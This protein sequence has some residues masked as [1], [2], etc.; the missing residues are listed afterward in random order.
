MTKTKL[1]LITWSLAALSV[2]L[3][4]IAFADGQARENCSGVFLSRAKAEKVCAQVTPISKISASQAGTFRVISKKE[5]MLILR[6][7]SRSVG[8]N[9]FYLLDSRANRLAETTLTAMA[10]KCSRL[11]PEKIGGPAKPLPDSSESSQTEAL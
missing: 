5:M 8:G 1:I 6:R 2:G 9:A 3:P 4:S 11:D 7:K 10:F